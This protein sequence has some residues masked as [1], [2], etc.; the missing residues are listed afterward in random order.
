MNG[1]YRRTL[2]GGGLCLFQGTNLTFLY[3]E[4]EESYTHL[5]MASW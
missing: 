4:T 3:R 5:R 1:E 2:E